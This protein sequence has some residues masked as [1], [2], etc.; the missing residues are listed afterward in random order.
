MFAS[1]RSN[2]YYASLLCTGLRKYADFA[3]RH[4]ELQ[5][6]REIASDKLRLA[7]LLTGA[8][9]TPDADGLAELTDRVMG[10]DIGKRMRDTLRVINDF[11]RKLAEIEGFP[12]GFARTRGAIAAPNQATSH[13][14]SEAGTP[15]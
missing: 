3:I 12:D 13:E 2:I 7:I 5:I 14:E 15:H 1:D 11:N 4:P 6:S 10:S 9:P 8:V